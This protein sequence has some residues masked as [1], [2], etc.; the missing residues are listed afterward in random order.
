MSASPTTWFGSCAKALTWRIAL[1]RVQGAGLEGPDVRERPP[2]CV[3][4]GGCFG[5]L[6][7]LLRVG[8]LFPGLARAVF[9]MPSWLFLLE[10]VWALSVRTARCV[11]TMSRGDIGPA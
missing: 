8:E 1:T 3:L 9:L 5:R 7:A 2:L 11:L 6:G 10:A 4:S